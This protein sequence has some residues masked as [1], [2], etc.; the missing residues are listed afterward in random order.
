M[1]LL[2]FRLL[3]STAVKTW[4]LPTTGQIQHTLKELLKYKVIYR[5]GRATDVNKANTGAK[6]NELQ[7]MELLTMSVALKSLSTVHSLTC[8]PTSASG[9]KKVPV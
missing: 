8:M 6:V 2:G 9:S 4:T 5:Y 7:M 3:G 1:T